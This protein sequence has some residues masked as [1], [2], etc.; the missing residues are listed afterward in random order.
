[1]E[2]PFLA[3]EAES[4]I[5]CNQLAF[6]ILD[7]FPVSPGHTLVVTRRLVPTWDEASDAERAALLELVEVVRARLKQTHA[8]DGFNIG[9]N[10]GSAAGQTVMH[11][12]VHLIPRYHG[13]TP[14]PR[15]GVR[16]C[17]PGRGDYTTEAPGV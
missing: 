4:W 8:P 11:L 12:H 15:G 16:H 10:V 7:G 6:A 14:N 17:I 5:A 13:D 1:V 3:R 2:S 9:V